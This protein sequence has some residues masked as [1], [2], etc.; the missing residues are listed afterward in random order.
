MHRGVYRYTFDKAISM[1]EAEDT[2]ILAVLAVE[3]LFGESAVKLETSYSVNAL[4]RT[5]V[6]DARSAVGRA[7]CRIFTGYLRLEFGRNAFEI[8]RGDGPQLRGA[9]GCAA[10]CCRRGSAAHSARS[11]TRTI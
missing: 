9:R 4:E 11:V 5:C 8:H 10:A 1:L 6:I 7:L 2:L 3:S